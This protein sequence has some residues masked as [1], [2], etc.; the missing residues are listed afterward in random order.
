MNKFYN[1]INEALQSYEIS[2]TTHATSNG[3][4]IVYLGVGNGGKL[5]K[6]KWKNSVI[7]WLKF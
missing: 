4:P 6:N 5:Q 1:E 2:L 3:S 7:E